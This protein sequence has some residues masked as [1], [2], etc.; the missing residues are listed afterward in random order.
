[1]QS[2]AA[3]TIRLFGALALVS[4]LAV[5]CARSLPTAPVA[6][7]GGAIARQGSSL[8]AS[9]DIQNEVVATLAV[10]A[11]PARV[12][13]DMGCTLVE[14]ESA[15]RCA[16][17]HPAADQ[18]V[19]VLTGRLQLD[20]R[21]QTAEPNGWIETA[22]ARQQSFAFDDGFGSPGTYAAQEAA[23]AIGLE[24]AHVVST[25]SGVTIA[26]LDTGIDPTH[27]ALRQH[28]I[29]GRDFVDGD[30]SP[31]EAMNG[32]DDD[33]DGRID[34]SY[35]HG[36]HVAGIL[37][38]TA[39]DARLLVIR[40]LDADGRGDVAN[41]AAGIR[42]AVAQ[43]VRVIN[44]SLGMLNRS[45]AVQ[46]ALEEA[47]SRGITV[48]ASAGN[49]GAENP[50][51]FPASSS[52]ARAV[53]AVDASAKPAT[54]TSFGE[55]VAISAPGVGIRSTYP[56]NR[57][58]LWSGT[59]MSTPFVAGTVALLLQVHPSWNTDQ[60]MDRIGTTCR[61]IHG[62][63]LA[64]Q[65]KLGEGALDAGAALWVDFVPF[66]SPPVDPTAILR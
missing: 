30:A 55:A 17:F 36:T 11:D 18:S 34:E 52:H 51:E 40:V 24:T 9:G 1:M 16:T 21:I 15:E 35:G 46:A 19:L 57:Y 47:E 8:Q 65:D 39:P 12:A 50:Q 53:A 20:P 58:R 45:D 38:L 13:A 66:M 10:G 7:K 2:P 56:G 48:V 62:A 22:E 63:T 44:L 3:S 59:S 31:F 5:G 49:W 28:F 25:G 54:F 14:W 41:V 43:G 60:V 29:S 61:P 27:P 64:Q 6:D 32:L 23:G 42:Y 4:A 33:G 26:I 37:A